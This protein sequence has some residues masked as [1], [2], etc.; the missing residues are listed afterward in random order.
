MLYRTAVPVS[1]TGGTAVLFS[2]FNNPNEM[3]LLLGV[4]PILTNSH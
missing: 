3:G 2:Y 1:N 4:G